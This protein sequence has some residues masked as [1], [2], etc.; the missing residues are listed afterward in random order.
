MNMSIRRAAL[1][2]SLVIFSSTSM[3]Q[4]PKNQ[5]KVIDAAEIKWGYLNPL[6]GDKS[7]G[8]A[9]LW[10]DRTKNV[11]T[12]ML[13]KFNKGFS[14]P[15]HI[16]NISY[17]GIVIQGL[18]HNDDPNA[19][20]MWLPKTSFWTQPAGENHITAAN[21]E[22]NLIYLEIDSGPYLVKSVD[23][24]YDNGERPINVHSSNL[25]WLTQ[26]ETNLI[27]GD[28]VQ[29]A[30]L[31][32]SHKSEQLSGSLIKLPANFSGKISSKTTEF[33]AVVIQ[34]N[35]NYDSIE[36]RQSKDLQAGSMFNSSGNFSHNIATTNE[37][38]LY[39]RSKGTFKIVAN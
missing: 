10:G 15:P 21:G 23:E 33:K 39:V 20:H 16:H 22:S 35:V 5:S 32:K 12:G 1:I 28:N 34:G 6:R 31:W 37:S 17:R 29:L 3:A 14:S 11:A 7:P 8:A 2:I 30:N 26:R 13:V 18:M 27:D 19:D 38:I 25:V 9:D 4:S 24:Q 36:M